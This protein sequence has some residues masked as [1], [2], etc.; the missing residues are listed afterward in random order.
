MQCPWCDSV[1]VVLVSPS[2]ILQSHVMLKTITW[3]RKGVEHQ[4]VSTARLLSLV[5]HL[6]QSTVSF[7]TH[8]HDVLGSIL[9]CGTLLI[10]MVAWWVIDRILTRLAIIIHHIGD[11]NEMYSLRTAFPSLHGLLMMLLLWV[12]WFRD[13]C[14]L[15]RVDG[16]YSILDELTGW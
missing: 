11:K 12:F 14:H 9:F 1:A 5:I 8:F 13:H 4:Y 15:F 7:N 3:H 10:A 6:C 2:I 16:Y